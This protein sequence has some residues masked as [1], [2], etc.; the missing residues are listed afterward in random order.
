MTGGAGGQRT[1]GGVG[2][3]GGGLGG[4][5]GTSSGTDQTNFLSATYSNPLYMGRYSASSSTSSTNRSS[6]GTGT[7]GT[8]G[9]ASSSTQGIGGFGQPSLGTTTGSRTQTGGRGGIAGVSTN[10]GRTGQTG[11][12]NQ[13]QS[14]TRVIY[15]A[16]LKFA[17]PV[18]P[19][20]QVE[21]ELREILDRSTSLS[22]PAAIELS[23][24]DKV[25]TIRGK[26]AS[27]DERS[28]AEGLIRLAPGVRGVKN[29]LQT[30]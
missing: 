16:S 24:E 11:Q 13:N 8:T 7:G 21:S 14:A 3:T 5:T 18:K 26:V 29:E 4:T 25:V 30:Q 6:T 22:N 17:P 19:T 10:A 2:G 15:S 27:E 9:S 20:A 23:V 28:L 12:T 1:A